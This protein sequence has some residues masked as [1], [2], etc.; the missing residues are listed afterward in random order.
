MKKVRTSIAYVVRS[1]KLFRCN[2]LDISRFHG[3]LMHSSS[4]QNSDH[5]LLSL[6]S[7]HIKQSH[8]MTSR[9]TD[10]V[11][12]R[13]SVTCFKSRDVTWYQSR[14]TSHVLPV[15]SPHVIPGGRA[16]GV[17]ERGLRERRRAHARRQQR[18]KS[19]ELGRR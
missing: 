14:G 7:L 18:R 16:R 11:T 4:V 10:N 12:T 13:D 1:L 2:L 5:P 8:K 17:R 15:P 9:A 3:A 6:H 19:M